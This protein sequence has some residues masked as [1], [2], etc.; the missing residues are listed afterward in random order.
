MCSK[1]SFVLLPT[2]VGKPRYFS[3]RAPVLIPV[4]CI[5]SVL[6]YAGQLELK[7]IADF[8]VFTICPEPLW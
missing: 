6:T 7:K 5:I 8:E 1:S 4:I 3:Q 2:D